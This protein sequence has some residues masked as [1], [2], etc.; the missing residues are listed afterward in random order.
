[1]A[2][3]RVGAKPLSVNSKQWN[4]KGNSFIYILENAFENVVSEIAAILSRPQYIDKN[5]WNE[6]QCLVVS[7]FFGCAGSVLCRLGNSG[8]IILNSI[9]AVSDDL[10]WID[11]SKISITESVFDT[12][13]A[14]YQA[15]QNWNYRYGL[16]FGFINVYGFCGWM[17][18]GNVTDISNL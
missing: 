16:T 5:V 8:H 11:V 4:L 9:S 2:W 17:V 7:V 6:Y 18:I 10:Y 13:K 12:T 1:M 3:S 14:T 15:S